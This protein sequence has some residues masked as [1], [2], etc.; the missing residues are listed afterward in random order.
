V[1]VNTGVLIVIEPLCN[2]IVAISY[3][4]LIVLQSVLCHFKGGGYQVMG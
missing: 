3:V 1:C 4:G 2:T